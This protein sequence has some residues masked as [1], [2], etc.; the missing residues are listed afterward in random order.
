MQSA[1][2]VPLICIYFLF[3]LPVAA[4]ETYVASYIQSPASCALDYDKVLLQSKKK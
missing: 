4:T 1:A 3:L 2:V